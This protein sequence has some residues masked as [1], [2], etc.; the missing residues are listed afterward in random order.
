MPSESLTDKGNKVVGRSTA[1][2]T[3]HPS[4]TDCWRER[5]L[6]EGPME[7]NPFDNIESAHE[8]V[9]LLASEVADVRQGIRDDIAEASNGGAGRHLDA[10][11]LVDFKLGQLAH[12][13]AASSRVLNDLTMLRR[14]LIP[15]VDASVEP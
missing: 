15:D 14:L 13:L 10:L 7:N 2:N 11:Q 6:M 9:R 5:A 3:L 8:Y 12:H 1:A 4:H